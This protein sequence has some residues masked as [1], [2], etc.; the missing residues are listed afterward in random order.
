[1]LSRLKAAAKWSFQT[2]KGVALA[3]LGLGIALVLLLAVLNAWEELGLS[4]VLR[5]TLIGLLS[6]LVLA[7][8]IPGYWRRA[9]PRTP[10]WYMPGWGWEPIGFLVGS[11]L[12]WPIRLARAPFATTYPYPSARQLPLIAHVFFGG[13]VF[14][15]AVGIWLTTRRGANNETENA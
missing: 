2:T 9:H 4:G 3:R 6:V 14:I 10:I 7:L 12:L 13:G 8:S 15:L 1:M 5:W 11:L